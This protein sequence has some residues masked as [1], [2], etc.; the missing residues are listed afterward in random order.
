MVSLGQAW[1]PLSGR[2]GVIDLEV[3]RPGP[4]VLFLDALSAAEWRVSVGPDTDLQAIF[5]QTAGGAQVVRAP[6]PDAAVTRIARADRIP[7]V[8][9]EETLVGNCTDGREALADVESR[10]G[11]VATAYVGVP[12]ASRITIGA[13]LRFDSDTVGFDSDRRRLLGLALDPCRVP[14]ATGSPECAGLDAAGRYDLFACTNNL[15]PSST[16]FSTRTDVTC[17][18]ALALCRLNAEATGWMSYRCQW[19]HRTL[20]LHQPTYFCWNG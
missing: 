10:L 11:M 4:V 17:E 15:N 1:E 14:H 13:D 3:E 18:G 9:I 5:I 6:L 20:L 8:G 16:A 7:C 2:S 12:F 19:E